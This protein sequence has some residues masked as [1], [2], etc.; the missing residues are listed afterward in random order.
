MYYNFSLISFFYREEYQNVLT[1][2]VPAETIKW[3][4]VFGIMENAKKTSIIEDYSI[5]QN[6][7]ENVILLFVKDQKDKKKAKKDQNDILNEE[8]M[9]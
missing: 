6:S 9:T 7:L 3:S 4:T 2:N 5:S 1:Y 8:S